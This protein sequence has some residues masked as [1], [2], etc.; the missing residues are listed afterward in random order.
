MLDNQ[1]KK[2]RNLSPQTSPVMDEIQPA[3]TTPADTNNIKSI[4]PEFDLSGT[5]LND[6]N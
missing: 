3:D 4:E 6:Y 2:E 5:V 1:A